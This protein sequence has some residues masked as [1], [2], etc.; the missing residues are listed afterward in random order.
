MAL[1]R[2]NNQAL[3]SV[4]AAGLPTLTSSNMPTGSVLQVIHGSTQTQVIHS[5]S[6]YTDTGLTATITP[7][8]NSSKIL[9][10]VVQAC[11]SIRY[12][13]GIAIVRNSSTI[14]N[15]S[16]TYSFYADPNTNANW[17]QNHSL[18]ILDSPAST[19]AVQYKTQ[20]RAY[21]SG[22]STF[23]TQQDN[24]FKSFITLMEIAG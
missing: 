19:S 10:I 5:N 4:T 3:T 16:S 20:G 1:T 14:Y 23:R 18:S 21:S 9:V 12:G 17:R 6:G 24:L 11:Y 13:G 15:P 22:T 2:L 8:S 7:S